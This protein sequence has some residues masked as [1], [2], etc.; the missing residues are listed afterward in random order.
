M[1]DYLKPIA[2]RYGSVPNELVAHFAWVDSRTHKNEGRAD[3]SF[4]TP[5][6]A[7][8]LSDEFEEF[9]PLFQALPLLIL[10]DT[11][12][13]NVHCYAPSLPVPG[14]IVFV[15]HDSETRIV[16]PNLT[17]M[18]TAV[19]TAIRDN[20]YFDE[21]HDDAQDIY[22]SEQQDDLNRSI[23][24]AYHGKHEFAPEPLILLLLGSSSLLDF[25][26]MS[27]LARDDNFYYGE[28]ISEQITAI[29]SPQLMELAKIC[30]SHPHPQVSR[31]GK[32]AVEKIIQ[33]ERC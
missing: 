30:A 4:L 15:P 1:D 16:F 19:E 27:D 12:T 21:A 3:F 8:A 5:Q 14:S 24:D 6:A 13:S 17:A 23:S 28:K 2:Q 32:I 18:R 20:Q 22:L 11:N 25:R 29:P 7:V 10:D 26:L 31:P 9:H 33:L